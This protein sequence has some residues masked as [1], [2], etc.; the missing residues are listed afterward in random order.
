MRAPAD[1]VGLD[2]TRD[3][4]QAGTAAQNVGLASAY[5]IVRGVAGDA[6]L[7]F[8]HVRARGK[9][10]RIRAIAA[11]A[12]IGDQQVGRI[13]FRDTNNV[14]VSGAVGRVEPS[15]ELI[16]V[17]DALAQRI[18]VGSAVGGIPQFDVREIVALPC[19]ERIGR[20]RSRRIVYDLHVVQV[21][22][23]ALRAGEVDVQGPAG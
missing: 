5:K 12:Q 19:R 11:G 20:Y 2:K 15:Q 18:G 21:A 9:A 7:N 22:E 1:P 6:V 14:R 23:V 13:R 4:A 3:G 16:R 8:Q 10:G 17:A